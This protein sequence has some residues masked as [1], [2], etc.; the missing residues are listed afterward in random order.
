MDEPASTVFIVDDD[1]DLRESLQYLMHTVGIPT[2]AYSSA[3]QFLS[4]F[5]PLTPG[6]LICDV[7]MPEMSGLELLEQ[8][9]ATG[10]RMPV[11]LMT[12]YA[13]VPMAIRALENGVKEFIEKPFNGQVL[14]EKVQ[15][16]LAEDAERRRSLVKWDEFG[17]RVAELTEKEREI[18]E[19]LLDGAA[20]KVMATRLGITERAIEARRASVMKKLNVNSLA[21]LIRQ[22]TEYEIL[23]RNGMEFSAIRQSAL[24]SPPGSIFKRTSR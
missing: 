19:L 1:Q 6:C 5:Q 22:F 8:L 3:R 13:D 17:Q 2:K 9:V 16:A 4:E 15:R 18:L 10:S 24:S 11:I 20:N 14:L 23:C 21:E 7:R 12:A